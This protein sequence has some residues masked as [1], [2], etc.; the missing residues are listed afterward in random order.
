[1]AVRVEAGTDHQREPASGRRQFLRSRPPEP[2]R[3]GAYGVRSGR[4]L[5]LRACL[6]AGQVEPVLAVLL[7]VILPVVKSSH[8]RWRDNFA[9][10]SSTVLPVYGSAL[11]Q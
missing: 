1:M 11:D 5:E 10:W 4:W 7:E 2:R 6:V 3:P 8:C 9:A